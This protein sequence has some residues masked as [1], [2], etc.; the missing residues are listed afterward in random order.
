MKTTAFLTMLAAMAAASPIGESDITKRS[1]ENE[2]VNGECRKVT[3]IMARGSTEVGNMG[4]SVGPATCTALKKLYGSSDVAC[5]GVGDPYT[6]GIYENALPGGTTKAAYGEA[7]KLITEAHTNQGAAVMDDGI[8]RLSSDIQ[9][10]IAGV[11]LYGDTRN[12]QDDGSIP[13]FPKDKVKVYCKASDGVCGGALVVTAG[14]L[15]YLGDVSEAAKW[16]QSQVSALG[17]SSNTTSSA[18]PATSSSASGL[19]SLFG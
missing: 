9:A 17:S 8:Q 13:N 19:G 14:H 12:K 3:F 18:S 5:Q 1:T 16:L 2:L 11:V 10:Q 7:E 6:A 15:D 4:E